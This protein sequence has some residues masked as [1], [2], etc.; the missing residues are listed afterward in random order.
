MNEPARPKKYC[1]AGD[2]K[3]ESQSNEVANHNRLITLA[4]PDF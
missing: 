3:E 4:L 1:S 2:K